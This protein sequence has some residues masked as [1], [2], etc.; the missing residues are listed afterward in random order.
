MS[1]TPTTNSQQEEIDLG[2]LIKKINSLFIKLVKLFFE[3]ISFFIKYKIITIII[4]LL[5]ISYGYYKDLNRNTVY[6]NEAIVIP[7]FESSDYLYSKISALHLKAKAQDTVFLKN[8]LGNEYNRFKGVQI[9]PLLDIYNFVEN[10]REKIDILRILYQNQ[11]FDEFVENQTISKYY[12]HHKVTFKVVGKKNSDK[13]IA[14]LMNHI[15]DNEHLKEYSSIYKAHYQNQIRQY[16]QMIGQIDSIITSLSLFDKNSNQG[17]SI[18]EN[19]NPHLLLDRKQTFMQEIL[20]SKTRI[21]DSDNII[22]LQK[23]DY[24][25]ESGRT[26]PHKISQ[27]ILFLFLFSFV[28]FTRYSFRKLKKI[29]ENK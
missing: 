9:E 21:A 19:M 3:A 16:D 24:N 10:S 18:F 20:I 4:L 23:I 12:K 28:F 17:V 5:G 6:S 27:P 29:S 14:A 13:I 1:N 26:I 7:N 15:N 11:N 22:K 25:L 2:Y 8:I